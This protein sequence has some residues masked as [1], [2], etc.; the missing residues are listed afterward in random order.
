[1]FLSELFRKLR[2]TNPPAGDPANRIRHLGAFWQH[3]TL[4]RRKCD[5]TGRSI[6]STY[7][8]NCPYPVWHRDYWIQNAHPPSAEWN[9]DRPALQ[10]IWGVFSRSPIPH[11]TA[12]GVENCEY[13]DDYWHSKNCYLSHN[14]VQCEDLRYCYRTYGVKDSRFAVYCFDSELCFE[15]VN[16]KQCFELVHSLSCHRCR[17]S[18]FLYDCRNCSNCLFCWNL[19]N[20]EYCIDNVQLTREEYLL[21]RAKWD[22]RSR[23]QFDDATGHFQEIV[24]TKAQH[25]SLS[26]THSE[27]VSGDYLD[28]SKNCEL[29]FFA[30]SAQDCLNCVRGEG[31]RDSMDCLAFDNNIELAYSSLLLSDYCYDIRFCHNLATCRFMEYCSFCLNSE[32]CFGCSGLIGAK[33]CILNRPYPVDEYRALRERIIAQMQTEGVYG[34]FFPGYFAATPYDESWAA[35]HFPLSA[36]QQQELGFRV[37]T[38]KVERS[39]PDASGQ[40]GWDDLAKRPFRL[41]PDDLTFSEK[42][43]VPL[44]DRYYARRLRELFTSISYDGR[45]HPFVCKSCGES[46]L[47]SVSARTE[48]QLLCDTCYLELLHDGE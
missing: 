23:P 6:V 47:T 19:R 34:K 39:A 7:D 8:E 45:L 29:C 15:T 22:F 44:P 30:H 38:V 13:T 12:G 26:I 25:R 35:M 17:N 46:G 18:A 43:Q 4:H 5:G 9:F 16:C 20:K 33:F 24:R 10:Q 1:M 3:L 21:Q 32:S 14:G 37:E 42:L 27:N 11:N 31:L 40:N 2:V 41:D 48:A 28:S 36:D